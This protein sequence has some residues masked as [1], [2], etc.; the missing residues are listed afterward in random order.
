MTLS[1]DQLPQFV[2]DLS[3]KIDNIER[4]L[5]NGPSGPAETDKLLTIEETAEFLNL[6]VPTIY[7]KVS[8]SEIPSCK[9]SKRLYFSKADLMEWV[10]SGR[11]K[12]NAEFQSEFV[13]PLKPKR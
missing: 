5:L 2:S 6:S 11:R 7:R 13:M 12:T 4:L 8:Q 1:F 10:K 3:K 9:K